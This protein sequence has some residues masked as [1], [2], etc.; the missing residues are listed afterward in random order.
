MIYIVDFQIGRN[1]FRKIYQLLSHLPGKKWLKHT[2]YSK[3]PM[4]QR[5]GF[6]ASYLAFWI[7]YFL[8]FKL[9][10]LLYHLDNTRALTFDTVLGVFWHGLKL[11]ISFASYLAVLPFLLVTIHCMVAKRPIVSSIKLYTEII[12]AI[13]SLLMIIDLELFGA[14]G[15]RMDSTWLMYVNTPK[16]MMASAGS[17]PLFMLIFLFL[18]SF[19]TG[20]LV[21]RKLFGA[22][23]PYGATSK[24]S[25][26]L[27]L[28][29][30]AA[31]IIPIRGGFQLAPINESSAYFSS[32]YFANQA[33]I[34]LPWNFFRSVISRQYARDNPYIFTEEALAQDIVDSLYYTQ[35][36]NPPLVLNQ[37]KPNVV[38]ILW[39]SF[40][41]K[42]VESLGGVPG[43]TPQFEQL[44]REGVLFSNIYASGDRSDKGIVAVL[45]GYPAQPTQ[46]II[47]TPSKAAKLPSLSASFKAL[48]YHTSFYYG[49][50]L[51]FANI[52]SYLVN[53]DMDLLV[54]KEYFNPED[55]N[56]KWGAHDHVVY[57]RF[58][59]D[60][61][62]RYAANP[63][64]PFFSTLFT[65]SS[66]EP[67][68]VPME[69]QVPGDEPEEKFLNAM[70]Y[71][72]KALGNF[73]SQ[74]K[75]KPWYKHTLFIIIADHGHPYPLNSANH[76]P[77][78]FHIPMLWMGGA[79]QLKD[80]VI[81]KIGSQTDLSATLL[82]QL[83]VPVNAYSWSK[84]LLQPQSIPFAQYVFNNGLGFVNN[85]G[86]V[87]YDH[88]GKALIYKR[89]DITA[90]ELS[91]AKAH[92]QISY[93][94][95]L[96]K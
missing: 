62:S 5:I 15:F 29:L 14:W 59:S 32:H 95:F 28:I 94:D 3:T 50:E 64:Q 72:D 56:S 71:A 30:T 48:G 81:A 65:L 31:L 90:E 44:I 67:F 9:I 16:E 34:N 39:E 19:V 54:G 89:G 85:A 47:K 4:I 25:G 45:S 43:I 68:E 49:G 36:D 21:F 79:L 41:A 76:A 53:A 70:Y 24:W 78:K 91:A 93:Q 37:E 87:T 12:L 18:A 35:P 73:I 22:T 61:D 80:T 63:S 38:I 46:S 86:V 96:Q 75:A 27:C 66:H 58:L 2:A 42:V 40:T 52:R 84:D 8:L 11:D 10:F 33:A 13:I 69:T 23:A 55:W 77:E 92:L 82:Q 26:L 83:R 20:V 1:G 74:A 17:A 57:Q 60:L 88:T 7:G 51:E 6:L